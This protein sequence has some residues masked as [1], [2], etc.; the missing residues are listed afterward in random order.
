[1]ILLFTK[2]LPYLF[3]LYFL[4]R[5]VKKPIY[6]LGIPFLI[7]LRYCIFFENVKIFA[8]PGRFSADILF[9]AW[10]ILFWII[11]R[12]IN[13]SQFFDKNNS[14][15]NKSERNSLD[16]IVIGLMIISVVDLIIVYLEYLRIEN[17]FTEFVRMFS[18]FIGFFIIKDILRYY[19]LT[20]IADFL[21][22]IVLIN[23][24]ASFL[25]ILHQGLH[26]N[27]Y[28]SEEYISEIFQGE[29]ITRTFW[30][31]P[32]L[33][34]FSISYL[35]VFRKPKSIIYFILLLINFLALFISYTRSFLVIAVLLVLLYYLLNAY[36]GKNFYAAAKNIILTCIAGFILFV[37]I[38]KFFPTNTN[39]F[40]SRFIE[41]KQ[42][43]YN[44]DSN[45]LLYRFSQTGKVLN[46]INES[47]LILGYGPVTET[48]LSLVK[49][50]QVATWDLVWT[51]VVF[52]WG[53]IGLA[54]FV[55]LY[56]VSILKAFYLFME[57]DGVLSQLAL[58]LLLVI[59]S[60]VIESFISSTFLSTD[61][62]VMGLWYL[63]ILSALLLAD[64][65]SNDSTTKE[66]NHE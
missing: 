48:Q 42:N 13:S 60:Q 30:F 15:Y 51:G 39:F 18:L 61:R 31:M 32:L 44:E 4:I 41:L 16:Y 19:S 34:F 1:M 63:G 3:L 65:N 25:Y 53:I 23:S 54:L 55:L 64:K 36:K 37:A 29:V 38:S 66:K 40:L 24:I 47:K 8:I 28:N 33:W 49:N 2:F 21:F 7:F 12:V 14:F 50:M 45:S 46:K 58:L 52:R 56:T 62:Y 59:V 35:F 5:S 10:L 57:R 6:L 27:I 22:S 43:P 11:F 20:L 9:I 17:V 26:L